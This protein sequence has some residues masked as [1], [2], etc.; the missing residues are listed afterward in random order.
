MTRASKREPR[1]TRAVDRELCRFGT[2]E[3]AAEKY[4]LSLKDGS[5]DGFHDSREAE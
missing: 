3:A 5:F 1:S 2:A 4:L